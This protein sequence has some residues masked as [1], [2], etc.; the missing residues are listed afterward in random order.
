[1]RTE[2]RAFLPQKKTAFKICYLI[3]CTLFGQST[4]IHYVLLQPRSP[5]SCP[6]PHPHAQQHLLPPGHPGADKAS[7]ISCCA[8]FLLFKELLLPWLTPLL[9][10]SAGCAQCWRALRCPPRPAAFCSSQRAP[11]PGSGRQKIFHLYLPLPEERELHPRSSSDASS[12]AGGDV[13]EPTH[14][15]GATLPLACSWAPGLRTEGKSKPTILPSLTFRRRE[16]CWAGWQSGQRQMLIAELRALGSSGPWDCVVPLG[17]WHCWAVALGW[18]T[19]TAA[20]PQPVPPLQGP[21]RVPTLLVQLAH[22]T[23]PLLAAAPAP[24]PSPLPALPPSPHALPPAFWPHL[25]QLERSLLSLHTGP[26]GALREAALRAALCV[27]SSEE[28]SER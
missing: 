9:S 20:V 7:L 3:L 22:A 8:H 5:A 6:V 21:C 11:G 16:V 15:L 25:H 18:G 26:R 28:P 2:S 23:L 24:Q 1:M 17:W 13:C 27:L 19:V 10:R 12:R 14:P 4:R